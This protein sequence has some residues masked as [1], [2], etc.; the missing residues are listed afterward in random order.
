MGEHTEK[1]CLIKTEAR[2]RFTPGKQGC[3]CLNE[4]EHNKEAVKSLV[5]EIGRAHV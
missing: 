1:V 2:Q 5:E 4:E 3:G